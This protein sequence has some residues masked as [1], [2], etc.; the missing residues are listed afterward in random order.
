MGATTADSLDSSHGENAFNLAVFTTRYYSRF[1]PA[2]LF[3]QD[4]GFKPAHISCF[5]TQ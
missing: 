1:P 2:Q 5:S 3:Q 4:F